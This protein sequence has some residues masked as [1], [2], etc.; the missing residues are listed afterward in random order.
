MQFSYCFSSPFSRFF[1][2]PSP[3]SWRTWRHNI[4]AVNRTR[5]IP[6]AHVC[7]VEGVY[8]IFSHVFPEG[9]SFFLSTR[10]CPGQTSFHY[11]RDVLGTAGF[12]GRYTRGNS[13]GPR[14][15]IPRGQHVEGPKFSGKFITA[16]NV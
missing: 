1:P 4:P 7:V 3:A 13:K 16:Y 10:P 15:I 12:V 2:I 9:R 8:L 6:R 11:L 5:R 14:S